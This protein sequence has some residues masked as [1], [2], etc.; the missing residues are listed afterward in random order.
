MGKIRFFSYDPQCFQPI[1]LQDSLIIFISER[2]QS[3]LQIFYMEIVIKG[4]Q[5]LRL[6]LLV[7]CELL[8]L[9]PNQAVR[10]FDHQCLQK[11][12]INILVFL[13]RVKYQMKV[14]SETT[15]FSIMWQGFLSS[16]Q[17]GRF[18]DHRYLYNESIGFKIIFFLGLFLEPQNHQKSKN[19][20]LFLFNSKQE[21]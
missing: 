3:V 10:S 8:C 12:S 21:L 19:L 18:F 6:L 11:E 2:N 7:G 1:R 17:M 14:A 9:L 20:S 15:T 16:N 13:L 5:H 4:R